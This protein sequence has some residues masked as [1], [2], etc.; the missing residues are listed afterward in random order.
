MVPLS[1]TILMTIQQEREAYLERLVLAN[2][3]RRGRRH[4]LA[5]AWAW[6]V[7]RRAGHLG[8]VSQGHRVRVVGQ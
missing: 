6:A 8:L 2:G 1:C 5:S 7:A 3:P 4:P